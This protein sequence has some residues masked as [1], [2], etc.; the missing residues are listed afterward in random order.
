MADHDDIARAIAPKVQGRLP[1]LLLG[2]DHTMPVMGELLHY[3]PTDDFGDR[4]VAVIETGAGELR[5]ARFERPQDLAVLVDIQPGSM[6]T[7]EPNEPTLRPSDI[8]VARV[9]DQTGG[10]YSVAAHTSLEPYADRRVM[11][12]NIRRLENMRRLGL[13]EGLGNGEF[14]VGDHL[15]AALAFEEKL[16]RRAPFSAEVASYWS[17]GEQI[18]RDDRTNRTRFHAGPIS[19]IAGG[20]NRASRLRVVIGFPNVRRRGS[21]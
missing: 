16:V 19:A 14:H 2:A 8:A 18:A 9:A 20:E 17:L 10:V 12:A 1:Q 15:T 7:F 5:Y 13:V 6:V 11:E 4:F 3:G 21:P